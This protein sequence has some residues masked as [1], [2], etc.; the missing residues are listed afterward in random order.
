MDACELCKSY[1]V[2]YICVCQEKRLCDACLVAHASKFSN[3]RPVSI[4]HPLLNLMQDA[5]FDVLNPEFTNNVQAQIENL[6]SFRNKTNNAINQQINTLKQK[7]I[8]N[9]FKNRLAI[10]PDCKNS[11][12]T[13]PNK[14]F[15]TVASEHSLTEKK[16]PGFTAKPYENPLKPNEKIRKSYKIVLIGDAQVGKTSLMFS[17]ASTNRPNPYNRPLHLA[18]RKIK[19][20][21]TTIDVDLWDVSSK[22][23]HNSL[24]KSCY[25][26][27]DAIVVMY[28]LT[29][30]DTYKNISSYIDNINKESSPV[31]CIF[32][33]GT[34]MDVVSRCPSKRVIS[35]EQ[36]YQNAISI[37]AFYDEISTIDQTHT[38]DLFKNIIKQIH[39]RKPNNKYE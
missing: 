11:L 25:Y 20:E 4:S 15:I 2:S 17:F 29:R 14:S 35:F 3:H 27:A 8:P 16:K 30:I 33:V 19:V 12:S 5:N 21:N 31:C 38:I 28:D 36:A 10:S 23:A 32:V 34:K 26:K 18:T 39:I 1:Q 24:S 22:I 7:L 13:S 37:S 9:H 6:E